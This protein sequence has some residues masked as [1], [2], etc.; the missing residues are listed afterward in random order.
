MFIKTAVFNIMFFCISRPFSKKMPA[1]AFLV[2]I[3]K[4]GHEKHP[5]PV[6]NSPYP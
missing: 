3:Q 4:N 2:I 6:Q 1:I 5:R